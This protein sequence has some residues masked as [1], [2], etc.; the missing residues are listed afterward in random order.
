MLGGSG[1][2]RTAADFD[3]LRCELEKI[4]AQA[5]SG[6]TAK[7][8]IRGF[9]VGD[10]QPGKQSVSADGAS[11]ATDATRTTATRALARGIPF[12]DAK[13][14]GAGGSSNAPQAG[15]E[16]KSPT[17]ARDSVGVGQNQAAKKAANAKVKLT[18]GREAPKWV[19]RRLSI[20]TQG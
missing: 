13:L 4:L 3:P 9:G 11:P 20:G 16:P 8:A 1:V 10:S 6:N 12:T 17:G 15:A 5:I 7:T 14:A 2:K 18:V 19:A